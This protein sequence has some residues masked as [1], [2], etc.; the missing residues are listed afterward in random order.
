MDGSNGPSGT[1]FRVGARAI[2][3][4]DVRSV[5]MGGY[6]AIA[7]GPD[8]GAGYW[9]YVRVGAT[10]GAGWFDDFV[11]TGGSASDLISV[12]INYR[13][14][15]LW[16]TTSGT[17]NLGTLAGGSDLNMA[18]V[19]SNTTYFDTNGYGYS[20]DVALYSISETLRQYYSPLIEEIIPGGVNYTN[21]NP[22]GTFDQA[23]TISVLAHPGDVFRINLSG[24]AQIGGYTSG[25][26]SVAGAIT[27]IT[28]PEGYGYVSANTM[29]P[30]P[31]AAWLFGSGLIGLA[32]VARKRKQLD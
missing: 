20:P 8:A 4:S 13:F 3:D 32:G 1:T 21:A 29:V 2:A 24:E 15:G 10:A 16:S 17:G 25:D 26:I 6:F 12:S 30:V 23:G 27:G 9:G 28:L 14:T 18:A 31:A 19:L 7:Q 11:V 22:E 5:A